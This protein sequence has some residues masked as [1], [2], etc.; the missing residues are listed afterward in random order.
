MNLMLSIMLVCV[1]LGLLSRHFGAR[2]NAAIVVLAIGMTG[3]YFF[4]SAR[5]I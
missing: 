2:Q 1:L 4:F 5:F 3:L